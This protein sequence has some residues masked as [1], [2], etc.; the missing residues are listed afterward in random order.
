MNFDFTKN[1]KK[2]IDEV[3]DF[4][5]L[6]KEKPNAHDVFAPNLSLIHI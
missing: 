1:E 3:K 5:S 6:E 2:F 4:I